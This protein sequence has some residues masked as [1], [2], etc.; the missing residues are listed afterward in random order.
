M[1]LTPEHK[2]FLNL[3]GSYF[4][5]RSFSEGLTLSDGFDANLPA[6]RNAIKKAARKK[7]VKLS[8]HQINGNAK[9]LLTLLC[10]WE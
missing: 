6:S 8:K 7:G 10:P 4:D 3:A 9:L 5:D 2:S 1:S